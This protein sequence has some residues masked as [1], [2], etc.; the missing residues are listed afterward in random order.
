MVDSSLTEATESRDMLAESGYVASPCVII[1]YCILITRINYVNIL[2]NI[3]ALLC[4]ERLS[5]ITMISQI[6]PA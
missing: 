6:K 2:S 5:D 3:V 1:L 4:N